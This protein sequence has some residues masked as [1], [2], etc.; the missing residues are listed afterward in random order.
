VPAPAGAVPR[1]L[2]WA[3]R[4]T[5]G[6]RSTL[7]GLRQ[8]IEEMA[9]AGAS[10]D[11]IAAAI[12]DST[13]GLDAE[14]RAALWLYARSR[15]EAARAESD[16]VR[17][18][19]SDSGRVHASR[20][21]SEPRPADSGGRS[22]EMP[23]IRCPNCGLTTYST[24]NRSLASECPGCGEPLG[25]GDD[26]ATRAERSAKAAIAGALALARDQLG[27][28]VA[29][30]TE[31]AEDRELVLENAGEWPQVGSLEGGGVPLEETFCNALLEGRI[32]EYVA[33]S[34]SDD[35]VRELALSRDLGVRAW[36][37]VPL[38]VTD[39]R[40]YMLCCLARE[41]RPDLGDDSVRF[42]TGLAETVRSQLA[43]AGYT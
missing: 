39:A 40:I 15:T 43:P 34:A 42:L 33:D 36:I 17:A 20:R 35:R 6:S 41:A 32:G 5:L 27:M 8:A 12:V 11:D 38:T 18:P 37:G 10:L 13:V 14:R 2:E 9:A 24:R 23:Y 19:V 16:T 4:R 25:E 31:L 29:L 21:P 3:S 1:G 26:A 28:D 7:D 22:R 30:L